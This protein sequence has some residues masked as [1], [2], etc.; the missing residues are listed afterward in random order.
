MLYAIASAHAAKLSFAY[1]GG[2]REGEISSLTA[3]IMQQER[4]AAID[5][6]CE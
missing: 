6:G 1:P 4:K 2:D 3:A 5:F